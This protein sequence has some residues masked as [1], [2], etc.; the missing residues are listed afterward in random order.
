MKR[1]DVILTD[2]NILKTRSRA[3]ELISQGAIFVKSVPVRKPSETFSDI[4]RKDITIHKTPLLKF[5]SRAGLKLESA[6]NTLKLNI[7]DFVVLD[8]GQSTGGF[9]SCLLEKGVH[10]VI[11]IDIGHNQLDE[12][13]R[14]NTRVRYFEGINARYLNKSFFKDN[15]Q[16]YDLIVLDI[17]FISMTEVMERIPDLLKPEGKFLGL[18]KPQF[19]A[20]Q[21]DLTKS[22]V[23]KDTK[24]YTSIE[25]KIKQS[26][27]TVGLQCQDYFPACPKGKG[28][29]QEFF[30]YCS[31]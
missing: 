5:A 10:K 6:I 25:K 9:T 28:G 27:Q 12:S 22:G 15:P 14:K 21:R 4:T 30:I 11:G 19:E 20:Q 17:S 16:E 18:V 24:L 8:I 3:Q 2:W 23:I 26:A 29:N 31:K 13:L 7:K 1:I